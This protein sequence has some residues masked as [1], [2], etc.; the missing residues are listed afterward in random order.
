MR[1]LPDRERIAEGEAVTPNIEQIVHID[2]EG[3][4]ASRRLCMG[5]RGRIIAHA[6]VQIIVEG[7]SC[8]PDIIGLQPGPGLPATGQGEGFAKRC[9]ASEGRGYGKAAIIEL[10]RFAEANQ[11]KTAM[12]FSDP[13]MLKYF[14]NDINDVLGDGVDLLFCNE[15]EALLWSGAANIEAACEIIKTKARQ[16]AIT[17][18]DKGALLF[19]GNNYI[20]IAAHTVNAVDTNGA[21]DMFAGAFLYGI[22]SGKDFATAGRLASLG[23]ATVVSK[24]GPR[25][26]A[27]L[28]QK[29]ADVILV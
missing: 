3:P 17:Q 23:S 12:T 4:V 13:S 27:A 6:S 22:T 28:H 11:V 16:F 20:S 25:L 29:I 8:F 9:P 1:F 7:Q 19:D 5:G 14:E 24:F 10:K 15:T 18:G 2:A 26:D 21:G